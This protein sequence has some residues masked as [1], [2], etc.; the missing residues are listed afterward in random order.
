VT[1]GIVVSSWRAAV[2]NGRPIDVALGDAA[3]PLFFPFDLI[4]HPCR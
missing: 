2:F 1:P 4:D 3:L